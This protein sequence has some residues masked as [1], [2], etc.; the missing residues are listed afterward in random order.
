MDWTD[1]EPTAMFIPNNNKEKKY[2]QIWPLEMI[3]SV[4]FWE[5][6][7]CSLVQ[8]SNAKRNSKDSL[9]INNAVKTGWSYRHVFLNK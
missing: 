1:F 2:F 6:A 4:Y 3:N 7:Q 9:K 8:Q 5:G